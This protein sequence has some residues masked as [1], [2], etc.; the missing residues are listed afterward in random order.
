MGSGV[1]VSVSVVDEEGETLGDDEPAVLVEE[2]GETLGEE[3]TLTEG[4][5]D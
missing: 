4:A 1:G 5:E 2:V 3:V